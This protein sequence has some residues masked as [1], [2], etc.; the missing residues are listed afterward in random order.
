MRIFQKQQIKI[1]FR[2][3]LCYTC[4]VGFVRVCWNAFSRLFALKK[5]L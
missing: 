1:E 3:D 2:V 4:L 5:S